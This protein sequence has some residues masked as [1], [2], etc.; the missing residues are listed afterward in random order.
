MWLFQGVLSMLR[1]VGS[2]FPDATM[3]EDRDPGFFDSAGQFASESPC[4]AQNDKFV[5]ETM[6]PLESTQL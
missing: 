2:E 5:F 1:A 4:S 6:K 3:V